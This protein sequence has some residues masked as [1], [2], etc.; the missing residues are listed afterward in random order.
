M[1]R[2]RDA[3]AIACVGW[4]NAFNPERIVVGG[5]V[6]ERQGPRWL[7]PART[8]VQSTALVPAAKRC[9][10]LPAELGADVGLAGAWPL[11]M[12]RHTTAPTEDPRGRG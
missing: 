11:V 4:V 9:R 8:V 2:A 1:E 6:A 5:T 10:I 3:F 12:D 7:E